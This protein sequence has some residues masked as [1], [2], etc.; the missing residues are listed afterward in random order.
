MEDLT[1]QSRVLCTDLVYG[2][3]PRWYDGKLWFADTFADRICTMD[4]SGT[5]LEV[6]EFPQPSG[7]GFLPDGSLIA[8][9]SQQLM[10]YRFDG[11]N[12]EPYCDLSREGAIMINDMVVAGNGDAYV[13]RY[14][15]GDPYPK[16]ELV[17]IPNGGGTVETVT[18]T[19]A[20]PNGIGILPG[21]R[22]LV[23]NLSGGEAILA[24]DIEANGKLSGQREWARIPG[25]SP[26]G[27]AVDSEGAIWIGSFTSAEFLRVREGGEVTHRVATPRRWAV[28]P[29]L[30]GQD[31]RTL[32]MISADTDLD[33]Y[34][35]GKSAGV[36]EAVSVAV[37]GAG[38]P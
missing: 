13:G 5:L 37:G 24:F 6:I 2:E 7:L 32:F 19:L 20:T 14:F 11:G 15:P 16:G 27:L 29:M 21:D 38:R 3:G 31:R 18:E 30:G 28:A 25:A 12:L 23:V 36:I 26:D 10:V 33:R 9:A 8:T 4:E 22:V 34:L 35:A 17:R 1:D